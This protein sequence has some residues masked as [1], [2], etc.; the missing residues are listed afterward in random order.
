MDLNFDRKCPGFKSELVLGFRQCYT[1]PAA[2]LPRADPAGVCRPSTDPRP[3]DTVIISPAKRLLV[4]LALL[5]SSSLVGCHQPAK[6]SGAATPSAPQAPPRAAMNFGYYHSLDG[7]KPGGPITVTTAKGAQIE[8]QQA[9]M[10]IAAVEVHLCEPKTAA[11]GVKE[12]LLEPL[13]DL[14]VPPAYAHVPSS[15]TRLGIPF[16]EDLLS[17]GRARIV[18]EI[19]PPL[20]NY[21][22]LYAIVSPADRDVLNQSSTLDTGDIVGKSM[23]LSGRWRPDKDAQWTPFTS[24]TDTRDVVA[25]KATDPNT[26][27]SPLKLEQPGDSRMMLIDKTISPA[28]FKG[29]TPEQLDGPGAA[30]LVLGRLEA[31]LHI[32]QFK[33]KK[34]P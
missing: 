24:S 31:G 27:A 5:A 30:K 25:I 19:A 17:K 3:A 32:R 13:E 29:L 11:N 33:H 21:C 16:V 23:L 26:G 34:N 22:K 2:L 6:D 1:N 12:G 28:L 14:L 8:I 10:V 7:V 4:L 15:A 20:A 9:H 18:G